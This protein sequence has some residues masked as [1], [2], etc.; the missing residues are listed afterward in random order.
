M[1]PKADLVFKQMQARIVRGI[2]VGFRPIK[3]HFER[4][5]KAD[6]FISVD[7]Q[8]LAELSI[9]P[10]PSNANTLANELRCHLHSC[11]DAEVL[12]PTEQSAQRD[13]VMDK[14]ALVVLPAALA[15]LLAVE[16]VEDAVR[17]ISKKDLELDA[18]QK[19]NGE[20]EARAVAAEA[21]LKE[22]DEKET[23]ATVD[24][25]ITAGRISKEKR[26]SALA[27]ARTAPQAFRDLY[28]S[29]S[30]FPRAELLTKRAVEPE[31]KTATQKTQEVTV[32]PITVRANELI[33]QGVAY[34]EAFSRATHEYSQK[35]SV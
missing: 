2:S 25:L 15:A 17:E 20:I 7:E 13:T 11:G 29:Q 14:P 24:S 22:R 9:V 31:D 5:G 23:V 21:A 35:K 4:E 27:L 3:Y 18:A 28:P 32:D 1:N 6:E 19:R 10:I 12:F 16:S 30:E 8:E 34:S 33:A 26:E